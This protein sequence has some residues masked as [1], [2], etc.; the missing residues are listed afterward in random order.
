MVWLDAT[1]VFATLTDFLNQFSFSLEVQIKVKLWGTHECIVLKKI[2]CLCACQN[3]L[4]IH[5]IEKTLSLEKYKP[6]TM[7]PNGFMGTSLLALQ[8]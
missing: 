8:I 4:R 2:T 7:G 1:F 5:L 3:M 6:W